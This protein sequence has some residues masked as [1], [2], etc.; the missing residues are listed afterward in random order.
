VDLPRS[1]EDTDRGADAYSEKAPD[2]YCGPL[3]SPG[4]AAWN[5]AVAGKERSLSPYLGDSLS[6]LV[7]SVGPAGSDLELC[8]VGIPVPVP[9]WDSVTLAFARLPGLLLQ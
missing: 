7:V 8:H 3:V 4:A 2:N 1:Q 6:S 5:Y 9:P